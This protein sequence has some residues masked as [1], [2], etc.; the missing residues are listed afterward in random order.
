MNQL[1]FRRELEILIEARA[2]RGV[3]A[4]GFVQMFICSVFVNN[5]SDFGEN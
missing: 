3:A 1:A 2:A 5:K 4:V